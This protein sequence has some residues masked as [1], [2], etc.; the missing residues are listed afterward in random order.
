MMHGRNVV[1]LVALSV[2]VAAVQA[3]QLY[4][5]VDSDGNVHYSDQPPPPDARSVEERSVSGG[6][7]ANEQL[8]FELQRATEN[9]PV[10]HFVSDCGA[11]CVEAR[12]LLVT[13]GVPH[14][15]M[16]AT[17]PATQ[18]EIRNLTGGNVVVPVLRVGR[19]VLRGFEAGQWNAALDAAGYPRTALVQ[20]QPRRPEPPAPA[21]RQET[22]P[23]EAVET[24]SEADAAAE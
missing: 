22:Q 12:Q 1:V 15:E 11:A 18:E 21:Q 19:Q 20:V 14:T 23:G 24:E 16:D 10:T 7:G 8:P 6:S 5:W 4:K 3:E 9:F 13:R 2:L 17:Q